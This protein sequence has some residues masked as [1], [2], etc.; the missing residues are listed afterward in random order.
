M[1]LLLLLLSLRFMSVLASWLTIALLSSFAVNRVVLRSIEQAGRGETGSRSAEGDRV[2]IS[3][4]R[5]LARLRGRSSFSDGGRGSTKRLMVN[6]GRW[7]SRLNRAAW[8]YWPRSLH[9]L[10]GAMPAPFR[11]ACRSGLFLFE[12]TAQLRGECRVIQRQVP[13]GLPAA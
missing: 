3:A 8:R 5:T 7:H 11:R 4:K 12:L 9:A 2:R 13:T 10:I 1:L 6:H